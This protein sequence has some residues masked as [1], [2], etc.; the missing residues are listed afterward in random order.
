MQKQIDL[1]KQGVNTWNLW[2]ENNHYLIPTLQ[3]ATLRQAILKYVNL[4][5]ANLSEAD[6]SEAKLTGADLSEANLKKTNLYLVDFLTADLSGADLSEANLCGANLFATILSGANLSGA[7]LRGA[8]LSGANLSGA[9]L[10]EVQAK[11]ACF[12]QTILTGATVQDW[13]ISHDTN[14]DSVFCEYIYLKTHHQERC[15][16]TRNFAPGELARLFQK[17]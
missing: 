12:E 15:P 1:I 17:Y 2:R 14:F 6:L 11:G 13:R 8:N 9:N 3:K 10:I 4:S 16:S 7:D 5:G